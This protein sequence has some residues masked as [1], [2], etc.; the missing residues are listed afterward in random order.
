[1]SPRTSQPRR[2]SSRGPGERVI[3]GR[4]FYSAA[5]RGCLRR[6]PA[7]GPEPPE[8]ADVRFNLQATE[9]EWT[10]ELMLSLARVGELME[11]TGG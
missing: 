7:E 10:L 1:M 11:V 6:W 9:G 3:N 2:R 4:P 8:E 5:C